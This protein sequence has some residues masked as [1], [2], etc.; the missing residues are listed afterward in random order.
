MA[1]QAGAQPAP[2]PDDF[3]CVRTK[4]AP[5]ID[6]SLR[7]TP[8]AGVSLRNR[9]VTQPVT[10]DMRKALGLCLPAGIAG[11][12]VGDAATFLASYGSRLAHARPPQ[13]RP[14]LDLQR[15]TNRFGSEDLRLKALHDVMVASSAVLDPP[16]A[17]A[18]VPST[19]DDF[20]CWDVERTG[21]LRGRPAATAPLT[22]ASAIG[23][24]QFDVKTPT[25][26]CFPS[27]LG[28]TDPEAPTHPKVL[29]CYLAK[30]TRTK[31]AQGKPFPRLA[32]IANHYGS[33]QRAL[34]ASL[35][36]CVPSDALGVNIT[37]TPLRTTTPTPLRTVTPSPTPTVTPPPDFT[38]AIAP[39]EVTVDIG[40]SAHFTAT[41]SYKN[42][43]VVD[44]TERVVWQSSTD[45]AL[46][47]NEA[48]DRG[49]V[50]A[51]NG[52]SAVI[53]V[54]DELTGVA[55]TDT[56]GDA[57]LDV[58]WTLE[59]IEVLPETITR[60]LGES[61]RF[62]A[63]GYF[64]GGFTRSIADRLTWASSKPAVA[65][66]TNDAEPIDH[67]KV[68][69]VGIGSAVI[70]AT[71]PL[72]GI[73]STASGDDV[74]MTVVPAMA[75]CDVHLDDVALGVDAYYQFTA[76]GQ[77]PG[78]FTRNITQQVEWTSDDTGVVA[79]PNTDGDRSRVIGVSPGETHVNATDTVTGLVCG[80]HPIVRVE[81]AT[82]LY[83]KSPPGRYEWGPKRAGRSWHVI[84][85][86]QY[87][88][89][90]GKERVT[91]DVVFSSSNPTIVIAP[92]VA[93]DR[94]RID[95]VGSGT[96]L[97]KATDPRNGLESQ[98]VGFRSLDGLKRV[99][100]A[101]GRQNAILDIA[102]YPSINTIFLR[103]VGEFGDGNAALE[104]TDV[105]YVSDNPAVAVVE[106]HPSDYFPYWTVTAVAAG[107]AT[108]SATDNATGI[109]SDAFGDSL[110]I[111]VRGAIERITLVSPTVTRR[112][113]EAHPFAAVVHYAGGAVENGTQ[114]VEYHSSDTSVAVAPNIYSNKSRI[115]AV[116]PGTATISAV[117]PIS[118]VSS[119]DSGGSA[120][121]TVV[122]PLTRVQIQP[123]QIA[124]AYGRAFSFTAIGFD[125]A[126]RSTNITQDVV[127]SSSNPAI[128]AAPNTEGNR[129][130]IL[131]V[132]SSGTA[133]ISAY[134]VRDGVSSNATGGDATFN[135]DGLIYVLQ[136]TSNETLLKVGD[137][138][139][140]TT[141]GLQNNG[142]T[143]NLTQEVQYISSDPSVA[144]AENTPGDRSRI[145]AIKPGSATITARLSTGLEANSH[146]RVTVIVSHP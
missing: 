73:T 39:S 109:S 91:Q 143:V 97:I 28:G 8:Q 66:P 84:A 126:G 127:W 132:S 115:D 129:S 44:F 78:G 61:V 90:V 92:N 98:S 45:T 95:A 128:A 82:T 19:F 60:G 74:T 30:L 27:N 15:V 96:A 108:I 101:I 54:Y 43:D 48:G 62:R 114:L 10:I 106:F 145:T 99:R 102:P 138:I 85:M 140:L 119:A 65:A 46:P 94:G 53:S 136:V 13:A 120:T 124:R 130:R 4:P 16:P 29:A 63:N 64:K 81:A 47:L 33:E 93:G 123:P 79:A 3:L 80:V 49:R 52:G 38:L 122:G 112:V 125:A 36:L 12:P 76:N 137:T 1:R 18:S 58:N 42:G 6:R 117:D 34:T 23:S 71:D 55:S 75:S 68:V 141:T 26:L 135:A 17:P 37:P 139:Q 146:N 51:V 35:D 7:F 134:D 110:R 21:G 131:A 144:K 87:A 107:V 50:D 83:L 31:P 100:F 118:G 14:T 88:P 121:L 111:G 59:R 5:R 104:A 25:R 69:A 2:T 22:I 67:S 24:W 133:T 57:I 105:T 86:E 20:S 72:S 103:A 142:P 116:G 40:T 70:S 32:A 11:A 9:L 89:P 41:A 113:G 77:Y 56:G